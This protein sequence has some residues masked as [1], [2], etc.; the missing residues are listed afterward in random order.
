MERIYYGLE[1]V[2]EKEKQKQ[3]R[4]YELSCVGKPSQDMPFQPGFRHLTTIWQTYRNDD[5]VM[6]YF[7]LQELQEQD[8]RRILARLSCVKKW[9]EKYAPEDML[10][11]VRD[12]PAGNFSST[13][14]KFLEALE[15]GLRSCKTEKDVETEIY[16]IIKEL[17]IATKEFFDACYRAIIGKRKGPKL[18]PF[19]IEIGIERVRGLLK[20][21]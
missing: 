14:K 2:S 5:R 4:I 8:R 10:F 7:N 11:E 19:I 12:S 3:K 15:H 1:T 17:N 18:A 13:E 16:R 21:I 20:Q 6:E 9:L